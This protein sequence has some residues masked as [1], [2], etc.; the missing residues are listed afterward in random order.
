MQLEFP[1]NRLHGF[2]QT[3][4]SLCGQELSISYFTK[5]NFLVGPFIKDSIWYDIKSLT[6]YISSLRCRRRT[7]LNFTLFLLVIHKLLGQYPHVFLIL[8]S[9][10]RCPWFSLS[11]QKWKNEE[12]RFVWRHILS[13][14]VKS[15]NKISLTSLVIL[16]WQ[17]NEYTPICLFS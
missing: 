1:A 15:A 12:I 11:N 4:P 17:T 2:P 7:R 13:T 3:H 8:W 10:A 6:S 16:F 14:K 5:I 9:R